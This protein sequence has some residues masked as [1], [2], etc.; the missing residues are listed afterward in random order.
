MG[1]I[2]VVEIL[3]I[4]REFDRVKRIHFKSVQ[5]LSTGE[6]EKS[7]EGSVFEDEIYD[8]RYP[9]LFSEINE[10]SIKNL[11]K[12]LWYSKEVYTLKNTRLEKFGRNKEIRLGFYS[13]HGL[14]DTNLF[15]LEN[16]M[17]ENGI[18]DYIS[19][20][21]PR[22]KASNEEEQVRKLQ[23]MDWADQCLQQ[24]KIKLSEGDQANAA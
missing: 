4:D 17:E 1:D 23:N 24:A 3:T 14:K 2:L 9:Y 12:I 21:F 18:P 15:R 5:N 11:I 6:E 20:K 7:F 10:L 22:I 13:E 19:F 8:E 16:I